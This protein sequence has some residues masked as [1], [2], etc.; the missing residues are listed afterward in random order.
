[1]LEQGRS[2]VP[3]RRASGARSADYMPLGRVPRA[4]LL[5]PQPTCEGPDDV[6]TSAAPMTGL[7]TNAG[8]PHN[9]RHE[10]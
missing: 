7:E 9:A 6:K 4:S 2:C 10:Q 5:L 1:M 3:F 8:I